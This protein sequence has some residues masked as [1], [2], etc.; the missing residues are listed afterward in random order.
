[1]TGTVP[2]LGLLPLLLLS[3][4]TFSVSCQG[5]YTR[6]ALEAAK[7]DRV[8]GEWRVE[9]E[10]AS[11][12]GIRPDGEE[13]VAQPKEEGK[14]EKPIRF[15]LARSGGTLFVQAVDK[16]CEAFSGEAE[17]YHLS[18]LELTADTALLFD[19]DT[20]AMFEASVKENFGVTHE[21]R[22]KVSLAPPPPPPPPPPGGAAASPPPSPKPVPSSIL[23]DFL[24]T[25][26]AAQIRAFLGEYGNKFTQT[27]PARYQRIF[28]AAVAP[29]AP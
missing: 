2:K 18:R 19:F 6:G 23:T 26:E 25:G 27:K 22:R 8:V 4:L 21:M 9:G 13:Y 1:M 10:T 7:D 29:K 3:I 20:A 11:V 28:P 14:D 5:V 16:P 12:V 24:L 15:R 17:C